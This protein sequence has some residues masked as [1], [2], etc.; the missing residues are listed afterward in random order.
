MLESII[1]IMAALVSLLELVHRGPSTPRPCSKLADQ[2][3]PG[4]TLV[5]HMPRVAQ[6]DAQVVWFLTELTPL[7]QDAYVQR[8][9]DEESRTVVLPVLRVEAATNA[10]RIRFMQDDPTAKVRRWRRHRR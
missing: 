6:R 5:R 4:R 10:G 3:R 8:L 2:H 9:F 1:I 7:Q